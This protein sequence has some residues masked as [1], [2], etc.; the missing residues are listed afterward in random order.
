MV[1]FSGGAA[2]LTPA[3]GRR[4]PG[5]GVAQAS[6][7]QGKGGRG[8]GGALSRALLPGRSVGADEGAI[9]AEQAVVAVPVLHQAVGAL[10]GLQVPA[11]GPQAAFEGLLVAVAARHKPAVGT[12]LSEDS[13]DP[14]WQAL[15]LLQ[16][17]NLTCGL[18]PSD[19]ICRAMALLPRPTY[20][21]GTD[22]PWG[23]LLPCGFPPLMGASY[24]I[25]RS[26][27]ISP[28]LPQGGCW[29]VMN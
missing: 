21:K 4:V 29:S 13:G 19:L 15:S 7:P 26:L 12:S 3:A 2:G 6:G 1:G 16:G 8:A 14:T 23:C 18:T 9:L 24:H 11:K 10:R 27:E 20:L 17:P 5:V 28:C 22:L 25:G